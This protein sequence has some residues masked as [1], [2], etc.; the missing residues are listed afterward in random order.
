[1]R[2]IPNHPFDTTFSR[3]V[4]A[5]VA[6]SALAL[7][8]PPQTGTWRRVSDPPP[9]G[10][11]SVPA[12]PPQ[13]D[14][15]PVDRSDAYGQPVETQ[16]MPPANPAAGPQRNDRPAYGLPA[17]VT[18]APGAYVTVRI[19]QA[20]SSDRN[21]QGDAFSASLIQPIVVDGI[22][23]AQR[24]QIVYGRV[25]EAEKSHSDRP[26]RLG[27]ELTGI[28]LADGTQVQVRSQLVARR[29]GTTPAGEQ[30]GTI[31][32]TTA[33]G[34]VIGAAADYGRGTGAAVGAGVGAAAGIIGVLLTR[35]HPTVVYPETALTFSIQSPV[36]VS[37]AR[38]PQAFRYVG[39][40]E[41]ERGYDS[42]LHSR[43]PVVRSYPPIGGYYYYGPG[44]Y[45]YPYYYGGFGLVIG[46]RGFYGR[47]HFR[48]W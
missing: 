38:A 27:L 37:L 10:S 11:Q 26:S 15:E 9:P 5:A 29:G 20:L 2:L 19:N 23:V 44:Y 36:V 8:Q 31:V 14:P 47:G 24:G 25:A 12:V 43:P 18:L 40:D 34:A 46:S 1:M 35:N 45:P 39:P 7:A 17:Q 33:I 28:T 41:Y 22:V 32:G 4:C 16:Q 48:R 3:V 6:A 30:A 42:E 21:Q 13:R